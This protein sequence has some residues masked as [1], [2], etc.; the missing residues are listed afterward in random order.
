[1]SKRFWM[2]LLIGL[3]FVPILSFAQM[4]PQ[5]PDQRK[6]SPYGKTYWCAEI[7][8]INIKP[9]NFTKKDN[10][11]VGVR[12]KFTKQ[13]T[14][15]GIHDRKLCNCAFEGSVEDQEHGF[16][17]IMSLRLIGIKYSETETNP[18]EY[19]GPTPE[20]PPYS[21]SKFQVIGFIVTQGD[22]QNGYKEIW[23]WAPR[24][25]PLADNREFTIYASLDVNGYRIQ[26]DDD[27]DYLKKGCFPHPDFTKKF[28]PIVSVLGK[29]KGIFETATPKKLK[30]IHVPPDKFLIEEKLS[31]IPFKRFTEEDFKKIIPSSLLNI[32]GIQKLTVMSDKKVIQIPSYIH[33]TP[34]ESQGFS[35]VPSNL[36]VLML[37]NGKIISVTLKNGKTI[38][39]DR[40]LDEI[41]KIQ[42]WLASKGHSLNDGKVLKIRY[43][44]PRERLLQQRKMLSIEK[45]ILPPEIACE[46]YS[47]GYSAKDGCPKDFVPFNWLKKWSTSLG[48]ENFGLDV[49][50]YF[51]MNKENEKSPLIIK[52]F[53]KANANLIGE[54]VDILVVTVDASNE[55][56]KAQFLPIPA[57]DIGWEKNIPL[58]KKFNEDL[59]NKGID[60]TLWQY[61][62]T[63]GPVP[64]S[65]KAGLNGKA[66]V[67]FNGLLSA[68][69]GVEAKIGPSLSLSAF[70]EAGVDAVVASAVMK[71]NLT[72]I[73]GGV[74]LS[75]SL[76]YVPS[77]SPTNLD[78]IGYGAHGS[79][80]LELLKGSLSL[81]VEIDYLIDTKTIEVE[82]I[83]SEGF[84]Y[85]IGLFN[86]QKASVPAQKC[87]E[88]D[89]IIDKIYGI[90]PFTARNEKLE[91]EPQ[92]FEVE[93]KVAGKTY[94]TIV[95]DRNKSGVYG[96]ALGEYENL[97]YEIP[98]ASYE[99]VPIT[100]GVREKYKIGTFELTNSLDLAKGAWNHVGICY[101][102]GTRSF[103]GTVAG[104]EDEEVTVVG[105]TSY[106]GER[107]HG[108]KFR[109]GP[110]RFKAPPPKA[111]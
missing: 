48:D 2:S 93:V 25:N 99:R 88:A 11:S 47:E 91:I 104:K 33:P 6:V 72:I 109:I 4:K 56:L 78:T 102:P 43:N 59:I 10:I 14:I 108:I 35:R 97:T 51:S 23:G 46:G 67:V 92:E 38:P 82:L 61:Y 87:H 18:L 83:N 19:Y 68:L 7:E 26:R 28:K 69:R 100:I 79:V 50:T 98:L 103:T 34:S 77:S 90:T 9:Q 30:E 22:L 42:E 32:R 80:S 81:K 1:M 40:F 44:Y 39:F 12:I 73:S 107:N 37:E 105:D 57:L 111:K 41:N 95:K 54:K 3:L 49:S 20:F 66:V 85:K 65:I 101:D 74:P 94:Y 106:W 76:N 31:P 45:N 5:I 84:D 8:D 63:I 21:Y 13:K 15:P 71:G 52:P 60:E 17:K 75:G 110:L 24:T 86:I 36:P 96:D 55:Y 70:M 53:F 62:F 89:L 16:M 27:P 64:V 29:T 58:S